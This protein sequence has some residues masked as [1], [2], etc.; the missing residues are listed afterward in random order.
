MSS[1]NMWTKHGFSCINIRQVPREMLKTVAEARH[2]A[3]CSTFS[4]VSGY[5][6][7]ADCR[8]GGRKFDPGPVPY[9]HGD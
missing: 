5:R 8:S 3:P 9:F 6:C 1:C 4:N 7:E 2:T